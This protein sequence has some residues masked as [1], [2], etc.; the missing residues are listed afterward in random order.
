MRRLHVW[1]LAP[2]LA[3]LG[4]ALALL[5]ACAWGSPTATWQAGGSGSA[6]AS[7]SPAG[8]PSPAGRPVHVR[9]YQSDGST[10]GIGMPII[11][12]LSVKITDAKAFTD[13]TK[14]TVNGSP[15]QG[16]WF[17]QNS[18]IYKGYPLEAHYRLADY[19][20]G[21][22]AIHLDL[23]VKGLSAG[24]GLVFDNSLT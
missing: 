11:A 12:Y 13:A 23:P 6:G 2:V 4:T 15:A 14:V 5:G 16:A 7:A 18:G 1:R 17:F 8:S 9:L 22:A 21:H 19:W 3:A 20:P 24:T 10:Y